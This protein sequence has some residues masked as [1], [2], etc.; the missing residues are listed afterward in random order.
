MGNKN[1]TVYHL[2]TQLSLLDSTTKHSDYIARAVE[3]G[4]TAIAFTEHGHIYQWVEK[5]MAC[6]KAGLKY[7]HGCEVYLTEALL[8]PPDP[9]EVRRQVMEEVWQREKE[10]DELREAPKKLE[11]YLEMLQKNPEGKAYYDRFC[12]DLDAL[13]ENEAKEPEPFDTANY[14]SWRTDE[15]TK[16]GMHKVRD[17]FHTIL[18]ARNYAGLQ[19]MNELI[20]RSTH[21]DH[22]YYKPR[23][24]FEEF[25]SLSNNVIKISACLASPLNKMSITHPMY[26]RLLR[27]YD[28]L[29]IQAHDHPEQIA[30][31]RHLAD[32]SQRYNIPLIAGTD[33]HSI[34]KYK[35][36]CRSILQLAKHI[37]FADEDSFDLTYKSY[38]ELVAMFA[39]QDAIPATLYLSNRKH[40]SH[41]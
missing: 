34:D 10:Y 29:E 6:E 39:K 22:F 24:T 35:A 9:S 1:Y 28:Y 15:L 21:S 16:A 32:L 31:N 27:H 25:L 40:Q 30:Y 38:D 4:Q 37:E 33:T 36:E 41:G 5:K 17:N 13:H 23:I 11:A 14:I 19:E 8:V 26:E 20:S 18:I 2:H 7:L 12:D 3:L